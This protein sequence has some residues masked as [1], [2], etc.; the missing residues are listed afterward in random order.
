MCLAHRLRVRIDLH[1]PAIV[2]GTERQ[3]VD[4]SHGL[5]ARLRPDHIVEAFVEGN[6][7]AFGVGCRRHRGFER[8]HPFT[9]EA[10]I[11]AQQLPQAPDHQSGTGQKHQRQRHLRSNQ[12]LAD[13]TMRASGGV[14]ARSLA[15]RRVKVATRHLY[16]RQD[17]RRDAGNDGEGKT[18]CEHHPVDT[19]VLSARNARGPEHGQR[20]RAQRRQSKADNRAQERQQ[21]ALAN[22][23]T[24]QPLPAGTQR[25]A[26]GQLSP[27]RGP[28]GQQQVAEVGACDEQYEKDRHPEQQEHWPCFG[29]E[30]VVQRRDMHTLV[31]VIRGVFLLEACRYRCQLRPNAYRAWPPASADQRRE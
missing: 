25:R 21:D 4:R 28:L 31:G 20:S 7:L 27:P 6:L 13:V 1:A 11:D 16:R 17:T 5:H 14:A 12:Q 26:D 24:N 30:R 9:D 22:Q 10:A 18:K 19:D 8:Q 2:V 15:N 23:L 29:H 3:D